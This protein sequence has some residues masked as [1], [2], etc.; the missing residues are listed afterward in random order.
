MGRRIPDKGS[1]MT[2]RASRAIVVG[3]VGL[4]LAGLGLSTYLI[5]EDGRMFVAAE[6]PHVAEPDVA[7]PPQYLDDQQL[8]WKP[9]SQWQAYMKQRRSGALAEVAEEESK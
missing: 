2:R 7:P 1:G 3:L 8:N 5:W 9:A 4:A 6:A